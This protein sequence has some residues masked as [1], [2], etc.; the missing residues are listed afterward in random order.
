MLAADRRRL[1][2]TGHQS[3]GDKIR[4]ILIS[5]FWGSTVRKN[6]PRSMQT[7]PLRK[8]PSKICWKVQL[9]SGFRWRRRRGGVWLVAQLVQ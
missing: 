7:S 3:A 8:I 4:K 9:M 5:F 6:P 2:P 1:P